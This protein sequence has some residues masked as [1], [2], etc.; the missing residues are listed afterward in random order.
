ML[1]AEEEPLQTV[2]PLCTTTLAGQRGEGNGKRSSKEHSYH[3]GGEILET[4]KG[5][6]MSMWWESGSDPSPGRGGGLACADASPAPGKGWLGREPKSTKTIGAVGCLRP[7]NH[8]KEGGGKS[9]F[10]FAVSEFRALDSEA[11]ERAGV[12]KQGRSLP[13]WAETTPGSRN[14]GKNPSRTATGLGAAPT[15]RRH[16]RGAPGE[17]RFTSLA[18]VASTS[19]RPDRH[20]T[21]AATRAYERRHGALP[22]GAAGPRPPPAGPRAARGPPAARPAPSGGAAGAPAPAPGP[23]P[24]PPLARPRP[25]LAGAG[26]ARRLRARLGG[27]GSG[28]QR[29]AGRGG[30]ERGSVGSSTAPRRGAERGSR[31]PAQ[32]R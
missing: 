11:E 9:P 25:H 12:T 26:P 31:G 30:A 15:R 21:G 13:A 8:L 7:S 27:Q 3:T 28:R 14:R 10:S 23:R 20:T 18:P 29:S 16:S 19:R 4:T 2:W 5:I 6:K 17:L 32:P 1:G 24:P 22:R